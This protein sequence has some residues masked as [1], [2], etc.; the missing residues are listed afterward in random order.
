MGGNEAERNRWLEKAK[1]ECAAI[2][3]EDEKYRREIATAI[4]VAAIDLSTGQ[5]VSILGDQPVPMAIVALGVFLWLGARTMKLTDRWP[6]RGTR[7]PCSR[8]RCPRCA[9]RIGCGPRGGVE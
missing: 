9:R 8:T 1:R 3:E 4:G 2:A 6:G 7:W 5:E